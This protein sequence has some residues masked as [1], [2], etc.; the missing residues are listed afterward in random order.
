[1]SDDWA[2]VQRLGARIVRRPVRAG[3]I[4][5][6]VGA[7]V[8]LVQLAGRPVYR[9]EAMVRVE[10]AAEKSPQLDGQ[11]V[12]P[13]IETADEALSHLRSRALVSRLVAPPE[14]GALPL[15]GHDSEGRRLGLTTWI[16]D[17]T[18][19]PLRSA[20][21]SLS[22]PRARDF[23]LFARIYERE[24]GA[25]SE[26]RVRFVAADRFVVSKVGTKPG[27]EWPEDEPTELTLRP[28]E[29][30]TYAGVTLALEH[31][32]A[33]DGRPWRLEHLSAEAAV[34]RVMAGLR[35]D[36][37][38]HQ[39]GTLGITCHNDDPLRAAAIA[40]ALA[41]NL[42]ALD[43]ERTNERAA[44]TAQF[45]RRE[46]DSR[47]TELA[48]V[49]RQITALLAAAPE[50]SDIKAAG[51]A[52]AARKS[53][54]EVR[55]E[56]LARLRTQV[57]A[58]ALELVS[59]NRQAVARSAAAL[60]DPTVRRVLADIAAQQSELLA[61][62]RA[63]RGE[64]R[65][66]LRA[67]AERYEVEANAIADRIAELR[68]VLAALAQGQ[69][70]ALARLG[71][72]LDAAG[73]PLTSALQGW[74]AELESE[75]L[76]LATLER[77]W[78]DSYEPL[79]SQRARVRERLERVEAGLRMQLAALA[80]QL[81]RK[82]GYAEQWGELS[83]TQSLE[84]AALIKAAIAQLYE[85]LADVLAAR[86]VGLRADETALRRELQ[87]LGERALRLREAEEALAGPLL[88]R[89][90]LQAVVAGLIRDVE[91]AE[92][93]AAGVTPGVVLLD[94]A[95][96]PKARLKPVG[97]F[98]W[99]VGLIAG[100]IVSALCSLVLEGRSTE[101]WDDAELE[102]ESQLPLV[103]RLQRFGAAPNGDQERA[104]Q[105][106][107]DEPGGAAA[108]ALRG[109][110][111]R[112]MTLE[113]D[114]APAR[115]LGLIAPTAGCG[116]SFTA[117]GLALARAQAGARVCL[118]DADLVAP[119]VLTSFGMAEG[120]GLAEALDGRKHWR[121]CARH[122]GFDGLT[123]LGAGA[124]FDDPADLFEGPTCARTL[125][126]LAR[127]FDLVVFDLP[128]ATRVAESEAI[129]RRLD[130]VVV[131]HGDDRPAR[132][133]DLQAAVR[134][135]RSGGANPIGLVRTFASSPQR[136]ATRAR[137]SFAG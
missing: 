12:P 35:V 57:D 112:L 15:P 134:R 31:R 124:P 97:S 50:A 114:G 9:T 116:A 92:V 132:P 38:Q 44:E 25:P 109:L 20:L 59:G 28:G 10:S 81:E 122:S 107:L 5:L 89:D 22:R 19:A 126:D 40:N 55:L 29:R 17:E 49:E 108:A 24:P 42:I 1:M 27:L 71:G 61:L 125:E 121:Q 83:A 136:R 43:L 41:A 47:R 76:A 4:A 54:L 53:D 68:E 23:A 98:A 48:A 58:V 72:Q 78:T 129:A 33:W 69:V 96:V 37:Q 46:L 130:A 84:E 62:P 82:R 36:A 87:S 3:A 85:E 67:T 105:P 65:Q 99:L 74:L 93:A 115:T 7:I 56:E 111:S 60:D 119:S 104:F 133:G 26:L 94:T 128:P 118:V 30:F 110:R 64:P 21:F 2:V 34:A 66:S 51:V 80:S 18:A 79:R 86:G 123:L 6:G 52:I 113:I 103:G 120:P 16:T 137:T 8:A 32:G 45:L 63:E 90:Q 91:R 14:D 75:R 100:C 13:G 101:R 73:I 70:E 135:L 39:E 106:L 11:R 131:L 88:E 95:V 127:H 117:Q 102:S 77:D